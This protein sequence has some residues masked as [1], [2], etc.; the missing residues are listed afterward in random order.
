MMGKV[1]VSRDCS[2]WPYAVLRGDE[3]PIS[4]S[5]RSN[6]QDGVMIHT[7]EGFPVSIGKDV[8]VGHGAVIHG[9]IIGD[10]CIIGI[11]STILNG[12]VI[13]DGCII[14]AGAVVT[15]GTII[16]PNSMVVGIPGRVKKQDPSFSEDALNNSRI[17]VELARRHLG[18]GFA[19]YSP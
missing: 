19:T 14:G 17:Y 12:A 6:I 15:P 10:R 9:C 3:E 8:T 16:P 4:I 11:R 13:G 2:I 1:K 7:D 18:G 5:E